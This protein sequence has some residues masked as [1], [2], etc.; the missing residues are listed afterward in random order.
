MKVGDM[1]RNIRHPQAGIGIVTQVDLSTSWNLQ[2]SGPT[3]VVFAIAVFPDCNDS[4]QIIYPDE[5]EVL[6][7][8]R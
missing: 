2:R 3:E 4:E 7:E 8:S 5:A 6:S 1:V